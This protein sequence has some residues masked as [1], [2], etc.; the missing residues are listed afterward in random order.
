MTDEKS[1]ILTRKGCKN[2][3][4]R[5]AVIKTLEAAHQPMAAEDIFVKIKESGL[6]TNLSTVYRTLDLMENKGLVEKSM[7]GGGKAMYELAGLGHKHHLICT[8]CSK[9]VSVD[10]CPFDKM[11]MQVGKATNYDITGHKLELY[12]LCPE[13]KKANNNDN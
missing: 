11:E 3:K 1:N 2:T 6:S 7:V 13:C 8:N 5:A 10:I 9:M 12:G 4:A